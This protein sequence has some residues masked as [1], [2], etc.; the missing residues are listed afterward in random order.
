MLKLVVHKMAAYINS[1]VENMKML[2]NELDG[3][4]TNKTININRNIIVGSGFSDTSSSEGTRQ[5][6]TFE[7]DRYRKQSSVY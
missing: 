3:L 7:S 1:L 2:K 6:P 4:P 5:S